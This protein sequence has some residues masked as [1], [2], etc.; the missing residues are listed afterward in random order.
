MSH[1]LIQK[2]ISRFGGPQGPSHCIGLDVGSASI[3]GL[4]IRRTDGQLQ[5]VQVETAVLPP[6]LETSRR[7]E[8]LRPLLEKLGAPETPV[9]A[10]VG[11]PGTVLRRA[12]LPK[13]NSQELRAAFSF[14]AEKHIPF[15]LEEV[16]FDFCILKD[17]PDGQMEVLIAAAR[18]ELVSDL[19]GLFSSCGVTP[20]AVDLEM[21]ALSNAWEEAPAEGAAAVEALLHLGDRGTVLD[22]IRDSQLEFAREI[23][24]GGTSIQPEAGG[25]LPLDAP[26]PERVKCPPSWEEWL[27]QCRASFDF[28]EDQFGRRVERLILS[29]KAA[30]LNGFR[31][32]VQEASGLPTLLWTPFGQEPSFAV[33]TGL[34]LRGVRS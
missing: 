32:W 8:G 31:E 33:A 15:K 30:R 2:L 25:G 26:E 18:K 9:V 12:S 3:Q 29:G 28:Y 17:R 14:E 20:L 34:A 5:V 24:I 6:G 19:L 21:S 22:F 7:A 13:M 16:F 11:G 1:P 10:S 27:A 23:N 4:K